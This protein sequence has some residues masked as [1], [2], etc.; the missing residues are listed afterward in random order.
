MTRPALLLL[1]TVLVAAGCAEPPAGVGAS[2]RTTL[3]R[4]GIR[5]EYQDLGDPTHRLVE[6][7][8]LGRQDAPP[9]EPAHDL[10]GDIRGLEVD[11]GG[12][13]YVLDYQAK[14]LRKFDA[15]GEYLATLMVPGSGPGEVQQPFGIR[16]DGEGRLWVVDSGTDRVTVLRQDGGIADELD[17]RVRQWGFTWRGAPVGGRY[18]DFVSDL[19]RE[20]LERRLQEFVNTRGVTRS[21]ALDIAKGFGETEEA[22]TQFVVGGFEY[23]GIRYP[24]GSSGIPF[25]PQPHTLITSQGHLWDARP[26]GYQFTKLSLAGDTLLWVSATPP[27]AIIPSEARRGAIE[28]MEQTMERIG[29]VDVDWSILPETYPPVFAI[30]PDDSGGLWVLRQSPE[31]Q[32]IDM[33]GEDGSHLGTANVSAPLLPVPGVIT[34]GKLH[35]VLMSEASAPVVVRYRLERLDP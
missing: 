7:L 18:W 17:W 29:W 23:T 10:F 19:D 32:V 9:G 5:V 15:D 24:R 16:F 34:S 27:E 20:G 6:E 35:M 22:D 1:T 14:E 4:G 30:F 3:P 33:F 28:N 21:N 13:I 2:S 31:G 8:R 11:G 12:N 26:P 25:M